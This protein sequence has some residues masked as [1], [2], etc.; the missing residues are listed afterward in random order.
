M[1]YKGAMALNLTPFIH[2]RLQALCK[3]AHTLALP[4]LGCDISID[5]EFARLKFAHFDLYMTRPMLCLH[6][7]IIAHFMSIKIP[8]MKNN[9]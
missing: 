1:L 9:K 6:T 2:S 4:V 7:C 8:T 3:S 5:E